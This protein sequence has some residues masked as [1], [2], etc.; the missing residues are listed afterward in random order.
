ME[1]SV[2]YSVPL[3]PRSSSR[4]LSLALTRAL[5]S[6]KLKLQHRS[7]NVSLTQKMICRRLTS[8]L[9]RVEA[10]QI[11]ISDQRVESNFLRTYK[12]GAVEFLHQS[13]FCWVRLAASTELIQLRVRFY[14]LQRD[15]IVIRVESFDMVGACDAFLLVIGGCAVCWSTIIGSHSSWQYKNTKRLVLGERRVAYTH[16]QVNWSQCLIKFRSTAILKS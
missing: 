11:Q 5:R 6:R 2:L 14:F 15:V 4:E 13:D 1:I 7:T 3:R 8:T 10:V 12:D 9:S 16:R